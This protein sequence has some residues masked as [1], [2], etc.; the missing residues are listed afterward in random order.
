MT[1]LK[2]FFLS[3]VLLTASAIAAAND[4]TVDLI[5][6]APEGGNMFKQ[7]TMIAE[8]LTEAG[9]Q[10]NIVKSG[11]CVNQL[12]HMQ[13]NPTQPAIYL[14][15]DTTHN[16]FATAGCNLPLNKDTFLTTVYYRVNTMCTAR[17]VASTPEAVNELIRKKST[18]TVAGVTSTP[19]RVIEAMSQWFNRPTRMVPYAKSSDAIRGA[20]AGDADF[21]YIGLTPIVAENK[22]LYCWATTNT[23]TINNMPAI[24]SVAPAYQ[25]STIGSYWFVQTHAMSAAQRNQL[26]QDLSGIFA[27]DKWVKFFN[28]GYLVPG[29]EFKDVGAAEVLKNISVLN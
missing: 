17:S 11:T 21:L 6:N 18:V 20:L 8:S 14:Y 9:Y 26:K 10:V 5:I 2:S 19:P 4:R 23:S 3:A 15:S 7:S 25:Y 24:R 1:K 12:R 22:E 29:A 27:Q 13:A 16:E 28:S